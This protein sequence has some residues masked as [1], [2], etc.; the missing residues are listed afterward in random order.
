MVKRRV[1]RKSSAVDSLLYSSRNV[2]TVREQMLQIDDMFK[3]VMNVHKEYN[4]L[5]PL[6]AQEGDKKWF[7]DID[8]DMLVFKQKIHNWIR[9][10]EHDRDAELKEKASVKSKR[11]SKSSSK[12][13][14]SRSS[15]T[16][17]SRSERALMEKLEMAEL[18]A[19]AEFMEK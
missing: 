7:D 19:E 4:S 8:A 2:E 13:S 3:Q 6:E 15:S 10:A 18:K 17:S 14:S 12:S 1:I 16:R 11:S 5:L 9:E